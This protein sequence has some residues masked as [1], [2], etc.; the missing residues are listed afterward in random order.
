LFVLKHLLDFGITI[1]Q[2][3][4]ALN[5]WHLTGLEFL[6]LD[7]RVKQLVLCLGRSP[8]EFDLPG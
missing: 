8:I 4:P 1:A 6:G 7:F 2:F 3:P 5:D